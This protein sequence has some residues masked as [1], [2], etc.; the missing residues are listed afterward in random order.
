M[1]VFTDKKEI[2]NGNSFVHIPLQEGK[3]GKFY[4]INDIDS[5]HINRFFFADHISNVIGKTEKSQNPNC[6]SG[7]LYA[8]SNK[9]I[10]RLLPK[11]MESPI[12]YNEI[13]GNFEFAV[14]LEKFKRRNLSRS[15]SKECCIFSCVWVT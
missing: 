4:P 2:K 8:F 5:L 1:D 12:P 9:Q 6:C 11:I 10:A 14:N 15:S 3:G 13:N 7:P